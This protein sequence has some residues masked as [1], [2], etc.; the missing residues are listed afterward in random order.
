MM[1]F[2]LVM[3]ASFMLTTVLG[4]VMAFKQGRSRRVA[5]TCLG[6]GIALPLGLVLL[7]L[8]R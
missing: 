2:L 8:L 7:A 3:A 6:I 1:A 4:V 5:L